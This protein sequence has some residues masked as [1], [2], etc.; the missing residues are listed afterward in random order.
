MGTLLLVCLL[1]GLTALLRELPFVRERFDYVLAVANV[2]FL[3][4]CYNSDAFLFLAAF[5]LLSYAITAVKVRLPRSS[6]P[7]LLTLIIVLFCIFKNYSILPLGSLHGSIPEVMGLSYIVFRVIS[8]LFEVDQ[9]K[10]LIP[11]IHFLNYNLSIFTLLSGPIQR[12]KDFELDTAGM[13]D[14]VLSEESILSSINRCANGGIKVVLLAPMAR[15]LQD[16]FFAAGESEAALALFGSMTDPLGVL[17]ACLAYLIF[18]YLNFSGYTDVV[19]GLARL[20]GFRLPENFKTPFKCT[21]FLDFWNHW[22]ISLSSWFRDY[23]YT[24]ILKSIIRKGATSAVLTPIIPLFT[25]FGLLGVWH[26]RT[27][28]FLFCGL[29]LAMGAA[30]N[31]L[32]RRVMLQR[33]G[34]W[35]KSVSPTMAFGA[36]SS[37]LTFLYISIAI[38]GLWL[39]GE[40][41]KTIAGRITPLELAKSGCLV[42]LSLSLVLF[43]IRKI[44]QNE[45][46]SK[47]LEF[48]TQIFRDTSSCFI[49]SIKIL[50]LFLCFFIISDQLPD[51]VYQAL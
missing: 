40:Q 20:S 14:D 6:F 32:F 47:G 16:M 36:L 23:C 11:P 15:Q 29:M 34:L 24:P 42:I 44:N 50:L 5:L 49:I 25:S 27:W 3:A 48:L 38:V 26:G 9:T 31:N 2:S 8:L 46:C 39:S 12:Y 17:T 30:I 21:N 1:G 4:L 19:I 18:L 43:A 10:R 7:I 35:Y 41:M 28:P 13:K 33:A 45:L 22:H 37:A 51:F